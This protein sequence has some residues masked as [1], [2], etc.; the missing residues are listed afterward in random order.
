MAH[1]DGEHERHDPLTRTERR[2]LG[3]ILGVAEV[4]TALMVL[5]TLFSAIAT[6]RTSSIAE[7]IYLASERPYVGVESVRLDNS[8]PGA[9]RVVVE[10]RNFGHLSSDET[11]IDSRVLIDGTPVAGGA[12]RLRAGILSPNVPHVVYRSL[13]PDRY[14]AIAKG[15]AALEVDIKATYRGF[16]RRTLCYF[17]RFKYV[18]DAA[19]FEVRGGT[20]RCDEQ[21]AWGELETR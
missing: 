16:D 20:S 21:P 5:A 3:Q 18:A 11:T 6:W 15:T 17:E 9:L 8:Q 2:R 14:Q 7:W 4:M 10:Y 19:R 12:E 13:P 1:E